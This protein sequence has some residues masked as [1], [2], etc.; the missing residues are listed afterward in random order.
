MYD[1]IYDRDALTTIKE[2][3]P[4][5]VWEDASDQVHPSTLMPCD[6]VDDDGLLVIRVEEGMKVCVRKDG[7]KVFLNDKDPDWLN[8]IRV[9]GTKREVIL[10]VAM[11]RGMQIA[12]TYSRD[13]APEL[14]DEM[15]Q[16]CLAGCQDPL[17]TPKFI[18]HGE[19]G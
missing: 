14:Q 5:A 11:F 10:S 4:E 15:E 1:A 18:R 12:R 3:F 9:T 8:A 16:M 6:R 13:Y 17:L 2:R 19:E 7:L